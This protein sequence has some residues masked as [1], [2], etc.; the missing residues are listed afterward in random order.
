MIKQANAHHQ[1]A[2]LGKPSKPVIACTIM[3]IQKETTQAFCSEGLHLGGVEQRNENEPFVISHSHLPTEQESPQV[4]VQVSC[5]LLGEERSSCTL[6]EMFSYMTP[7]PA[8]L[9]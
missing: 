2:S 4:S 5:S 7:S 8:W 9:L 6:A 1:A 3:C